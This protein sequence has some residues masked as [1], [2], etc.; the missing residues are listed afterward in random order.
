[1]KNDM[2]IADHPASNEQMSYC[3]TTESSEEFSSR[4]YRF[5]LASIAPAGDFVNIWRYP[6][7]VRRHGGIVLFSVLI[8]Y[9]LIGWPIYMFELSLG[10]LAAKKQFPGHCLNNFMP[11][12]KGLDIASILYMIAT[13]LYQMTI[14][15]WILYYLFTSVQ[16]T[17]PWSVC[18]NSTHSTDCVIIQRNHTCREFNIC[19]NSSN[20]TVPEVSG[21]KY[22]FNIISPSSSLENAGDSSWALIL[23]LLFAWFIVYLN[24][25]KNKLTMRKKKFIPTALIIFIFT[26]FFAFSFKYKGNIEGITSYLKFDGGKLAD[27]LLW[28]D[29]LTQVILS[30]NIGSGFITVSSKQGLNREHITLTSIGIILTNYV[31]SFY[32]GLVIYSWFGTLANASQLSVFSLLPA[33]FGFSFI[34][35]SSA[36]ATLPIPPVWSIAIFLIMSFASFDRVEKI[37]LTLI[38][39]LHQLFF[40]NLFKDHSKKMILVLYILLFCSGIIFTYGIGYH[41]LFVLDCW[42]FGFAALFLSLLHIACIYW[43][44]GFQ[45]LFEEL[46]TILKGNMEQKLFKVLWC[47]VTPTISV[48]LLIFIC[49]NNN[50]PF[51]GMFYY[52]R[53][54]QV[55]GWCIVFLIL[56][57]C[58][59]YLSYV[60]SK[61]IWTSKNSKEELSEVN[62]VSGN[63]RNSIHN[64]IRE[65][66]TKQESNEAPLTYH[67]LL[68]KSENKG[69]SSNIPYGFILSPSKHKIITKKFPNLLNYPEI[70]INSV[71]AI[72]PESSISDFYSISQPTSQTGSLH[73]SP[74]IIKRHSEGEISGYKIR[75]HSEFNL[76]NNDNDKGLVNQ[77]FCHQD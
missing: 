15:S 23:C 9:I 5:L 10:Y 64:I 77:A 47:V 2:E 35:L 16:E 69:T 11:L 39:S 74:D 30:L 19:L 51:L 65:Q 7:L 60:I 42:V 67:V 62:S 63:I 73:F 41:I 1:M 32:G 76:L 48:A 71:S 68:I 55:V 75:R 22:F 21:R 61:A 14:I 28:N 29:S 49:T 12:L 46:H 8:I 58:F 13:L 6:Y 43:L 34:V 44:Y 4:K 72:E 66:Q 45:I 33:D 40:T 20:V 26:A 36:I 31:I 50:L 25:M 54:A 56:S 52:G 59:I 24:T 70:V 18:E 57:P 17:V 27:P 37:T 38:S 53:L 3:D